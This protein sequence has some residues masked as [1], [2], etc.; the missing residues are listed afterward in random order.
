MKGQ[1]GSYNIGG[2]NCVSNNKIIEKL[3]IKFNQVANTNFD[4]NEMTENIDRLGHTK[5][6]VDT[7]SYKIKVK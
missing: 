3:I 4:F 1:A 6:D 5:Y 7:I 2:N